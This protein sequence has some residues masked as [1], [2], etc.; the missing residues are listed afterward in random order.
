ML[1]DLL[2]KNWAGLDGTFSAHSYKA[3]KS[4]GVHLTPGGFL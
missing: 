4:L 3:R 1:S 2:A